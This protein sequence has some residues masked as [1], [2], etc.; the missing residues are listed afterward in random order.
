MNITNV[1]I[2]DSGSMQRK[3]RI[4]VFASKNVLEDAQTRF[5]KP[6]KAYKQDILP[7]VLK[8]MGLA[9][10]TKAKWSQTAGCAC[11]CSPGFIVAEDLGRDVFVDVA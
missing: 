10:D 3:T 7:Q 1:N 8:V 4:H 2:Q 9:K 11:G 6:F 5:N